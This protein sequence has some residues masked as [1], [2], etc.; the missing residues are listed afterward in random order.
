VA[1]RAAG[2]KSTTLLLIGQFIIA[3]YGGYFGAGM[4]VLMIALFLAAANM[5][6]QSASG[7][8]LICA[9]AV[10]LLAVLLF[11]L[12]G[13]LDWKTGIPML[14]AGIA[15]GYLGAR[16]MRRLDEK[17]ARYTILVYAWGLTV[18]FFLRR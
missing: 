4:G 13:A 16:V 1:A 6:V 12:R 9:T 7:L 17:A 3:V 2:H 18:W 10:N 15:G 8:R 14:I 5:E 11:A